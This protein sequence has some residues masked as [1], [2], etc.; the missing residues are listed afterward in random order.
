MLLASHGTT[1]PLALIRPGS[2]GENKHEVVKM[3]VHDPD[4]EEM[5]WMSGRMAWDELSG[6]LCVP[7]SFDDSV[8]VLEY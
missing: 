4:L 8:V 2:R 1:T 3:G 6:R 5:M 7:N